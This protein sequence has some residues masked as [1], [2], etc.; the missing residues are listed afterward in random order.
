MIANRFKA[1]RRF[2]LPWLSDKIDFAEARIVE[3]GCGSGSSTAALALHAKSVRGYDID[4]ASVRAAAA[5]CKAYGVTN[6]ELAAV[7]P[8]TLLATV[9]SRSE[10]TN[11]YLLYAVLEH[12]T[13]PERLE[14]LSTLWN[15]LPAGGHLVIVETPNRLTYVDRHTTE[16]PFFHMLPDYLAFRYLDRSGRAAFKDAMR[17]PL[18]KG[19]DEASLT[20]I[21][22]GLGASFHEF[23]LAIAEP[24]E[25]IIVADGL[26]R[27]MTDFFP[28]ELDEKILERFFLE[29]PI[30]KPMGFC[31]GV[32]NLILRKPRDASDREE[33]RAYHLKRR[34]EMTP[35]PPAPPPPPPAPPPPPPPP[36][37]TPTL[38][39]WFRHRVARLRRR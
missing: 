30:Q 29:E 20:R 6:V 15:A 26:E 9:T 35:P 28:R 1:E 39:A 12:L 14:T 31:R 16:L 37:P 8:E 4:A 24:L 32:I 25:E 27:E 17:E 18:S 19:P 11:V 22:W 3:I 5:R 21:R 2:Q 33:A 7:E 34:A 23:E 38:S 13:Y 36:P 10:E